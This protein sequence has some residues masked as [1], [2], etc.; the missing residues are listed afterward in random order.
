MAVAMWRFVAGPL[1]GDAEAL[2]FAFYLECL[3]GAVGCN[4]QRAAPSPPSSSP[5]RYRRAALSSGPCRRLPRRRLQGVVT[6]RRRQPAY[7]GEVALPGEITLS[8]CPLAHELFGL[9]PS[10]L[11][12]F[13]ITND[14]HF[15]FLRAGSHRK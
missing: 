1:A 7:S 11:P 15:P 6:R 2:R 3:L 5:P 4:E 9:T 12:D 13:F 14:A 8:T 10:F